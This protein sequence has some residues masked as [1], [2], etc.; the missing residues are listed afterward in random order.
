VQRWRDGSQV[1]EHAPIEQTSVIAQAWPH[2]PQFDGSFVVDV[3]IVPPVAPGQAVC[4]TAH[5]AL[6]A[7]LSQR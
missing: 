1:D 2:A 6:Q 4:P 7:P 5:V 3:Q